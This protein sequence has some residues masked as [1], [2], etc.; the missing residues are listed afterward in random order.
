[1]N[2]FQKKQILRVESEMFVGKSW[3]NICHSLFTCCINAHKHVPT[4]TSEPYCI[5]LCSL[6][7]CYDCTHPRRNIPYDEED[8]RRT[9]E[10]EEVY[11]AYKD[12]RDKQ[13]QTYKDFHGPVRKS[14]VCK[15]LGC[16]R[17][18]GR[19]GFIFCTEG[20]T[21]CCSKKSKDPAPSF[22]YGDIDDINDASVVLRKVLGEPPMN[23]TYH[24]WEWDEESNQFDLVPPAEGNESESLTNRKVKSFKD[25][26]TQSQSTG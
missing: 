24:R 5:P 10:L 16:R 3:L 4:R 11:D 23:V 7:C 26:R 13:V 17:V 21:D 25:L 20:C 18:F 8:P 22:T 2:T 6:S 9:R 12:S 19:R 14:T 1:M 15:A